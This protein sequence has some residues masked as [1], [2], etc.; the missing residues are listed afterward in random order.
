MPQKNDSIN[1]IFDI[2]LHYFLTFE[3]QKLFK[4]NRFW[5]KKGYASYNVNFTFLKRNQVYRCG[6]KVVPFGVGWYY[7]VLKNKQ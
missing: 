4:C 7:T 1:N 5:K 3:I 6:C 2:V